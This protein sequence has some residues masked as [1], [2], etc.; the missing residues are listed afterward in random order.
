[1]G[2]PLTRST[3]IEFANRIINQ[4]EYEEQVEA[5]KK[6]RGLHD[7]NK[8]GIRWYHGFLNRHATLLTTSGT[9]IKDVK[10][11]TWVTKEN[12]ENM[13]ENV[14]KTM[15]EAGV[16]EEV[17]EEIQHEAGLP[18]KFR[19]TRPEYILFVDETGCNTNQLNDGRV[20]NELFIVPKVDSECGA[21]TGAT[22]DIHF[23][24][25]PFISGTGEA[26]MCAIIFKSEQD[27]SEIPIS[28]KTGIDITCENVEDTTN[29]MR[30][31]AYLYF[32]RENH[33]LLFWN[34]SKS[35]YHN[36]PSHGNA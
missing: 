32:P 17:S 36:H 34:F 21:P 33:S 11:R 35:Q 30:G 8:L 14:Y 24:V 4:T 7:A 1:M 6:L 29:V 9:V 31:G 13:Y 26:V 25:L 18:S 20:G 16:A 15:V 22:T 28:W 2:Q 5:A 27:V 10:R 19:L 23:T 12:F 3:V